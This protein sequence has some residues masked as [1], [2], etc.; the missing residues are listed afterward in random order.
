MLFTF[1]SAISIFALTPLYLTGSAKSDGSFLYKISIANIVGSNFKAFIVFSVNVGIACLS[2]YML[3][4][5]WETSVKWRHVN[6]TH[7]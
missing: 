4:L 5:Y 7:S 2:F 6:H 3:K 1:V